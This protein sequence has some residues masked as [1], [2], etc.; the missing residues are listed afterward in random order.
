[1]KEL[2]AA[3]RT[4]RE[5]AWREARLHV[6]LRQGGDRGAEAFPVV[7]AAVDGND[8]VYHE[9]YD[10]GVA[11]STERGLIVPVLRD[12]DLLSFRADREG[13]RRL[14]RPRAFGFARPSKT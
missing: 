14:R 1:V 6:V 2:R 4:L 3:T 10:I 7:N 13:H 9:Y 12:A 8:I 5:E 11:V